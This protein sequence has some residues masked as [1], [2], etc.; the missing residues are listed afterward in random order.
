[1][2]IERPPQQNAVFETFER[3]RSGDQELAA[4]TE[5][6]GL[7]PREL[8]SG[9]TVLTMAADRRNHNVFGTIHGGLLC[10]FADV[11]MGVALRARSTTRDSP[12]SGST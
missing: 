4:V 11:A 8:E 5:L 12:P 7:R 6:L 2:T 10:A 1:M 9:R 3:W